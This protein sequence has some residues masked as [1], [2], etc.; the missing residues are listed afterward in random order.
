MKTI[1]FFIASSALLFACNTTTHAQNTFFPT[2]AGTVLT[3]MQNDAKGKADAY[4]Q[5]TIENVEGSE[6]N[7]TVSYSVVMMDK[8]RKPI[9]DPIPLK[10]TIQDD[11]VFLD[12]KELFAGMKTDTQIE[13]EYSGVPIELPANL[14]PGQSLKDAEA[15]MTVNLGIM[16][17]TTSIKM[18]DGKCLAIEDFTVPAGT[19]KCHKMTQSVATT[20]MKKTV[21][22][23]TVSWY[24]PGIGTVKNETYDAK[25]KLSGSMELIEIKK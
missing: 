23:R 17:M 15:I 22:S 21:N 2:K 25:D 6:R 10:V 14:Q 16:K 20:V 1:N 4:L 7:M 8:N 19:F 13:V 5:Y 12:M 24:T 18:T 11:V 3:Y 9:N